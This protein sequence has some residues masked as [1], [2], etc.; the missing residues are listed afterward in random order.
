M[1]KSILAA[2]VAAAIA[3]S[4]TAVC[5]CPFN[6]ADN[7]GNSNTYASNSSPHGQGGTVPSSTN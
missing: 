6:A 3:L 2:A 1:S 4:A 7:A 5:A